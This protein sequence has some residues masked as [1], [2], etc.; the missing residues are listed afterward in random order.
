M[1]A[2]QVGYWRE[3]H[4]TRLLRCLLWGTTCAMS[5]DEVLVACAGRCVGCAGRPSA[6][7]AAS[8]SPANTT[9]QRKHNC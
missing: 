7:Q 4:K 3:T 5:S 6:S 1:Q 9:C 2:C 8:I